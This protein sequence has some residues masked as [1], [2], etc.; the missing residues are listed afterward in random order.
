MSYDR[1]Y[2]C[3]SLDE[4]TWDEVLFGE[5]QGRSEEE[6]ESEH[7]RLYK[8]GDFVVLSAG[9]NFGFDEIYL[10]EQRADAERFYRTDFASRECVMDQG[11]CGFQEI[12]LYRGG[13]LV[14]TKDQPSPDED[15]FRFGI[16]KSKVAPEMYEHLN[17]EW[18]LRCPFPISFYTRV[19]KGC[20]HAER[21]PGEVDG[22]T[23]P[24]NLTRQF[25]RSSDNA[26][27]ENGEEQPPDGFREDEPQ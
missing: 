8:K 17:K 13:R 12:S 24:A 7:G 23:Y 21:P 14:A 10:F 11:R 15:N 6:L 1:I 16:V 3:R 9:V 4:R 18:V 25:A 22:A 2:L 19:G 20:L 27:A 26:R 5:R